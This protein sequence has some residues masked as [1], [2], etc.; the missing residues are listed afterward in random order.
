MANS[1]RTRSTPVSIGRVNSPLAVSG[2]LARKARIRPSVA[3]CSCS[4]MTSNPARVAIAA[5]RESAVRRCPCG[6][7]ACSGEPNRATRPVFGRCAPA[8]S[9][10]Q[11]LNVSRGPMAALP[12]TRSSPATHSTRLSMTFHRPARMPPGTRTLAI[13]GPATSMSNQCRA[14]PA[15]TASTDASGSGTA[16]ALPGRA[17]TAGSARHSSVSIAGS[18]STATTSAPSATSVAVSLPV[19]AP[20]SSTRGPGAGSSAQRTAACA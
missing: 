9:A 20:R 10:R 18:G 8:V 16:S 3:S 19:P 13:S 11:L 15:S 14:W 2:L 5:T 7:S 4:G 17:R 6:N 12:L 1:R